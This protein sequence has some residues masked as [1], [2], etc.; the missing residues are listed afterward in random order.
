MQKRPYGDHHIAIDDS[1]DPDWSSMQPVDDVASWFDQLEDSIL[2]DSDKIEG[3]HRHETIDVQTTAS[4]TSSS[5]PDTTTTTTTTNSQ[6]TTRRRSRG[7]A[8]HRRQSTTVNLPSPTT[9]LPAVTPAAT[10]PEVVPLR[11]ILD[12]SKSEDVIE[13]PAGK[14]HKDEDEDDTALFNGQY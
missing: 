14:H 9:T 2:E 3:L 11:G 7:G 13:Q 8:S 6:P 4:T 5:I 12:V 1:L 10:Q